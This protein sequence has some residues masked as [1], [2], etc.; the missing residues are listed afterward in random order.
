METKNEPHLTLSDAN[1]KEILMP[2]ERTE[3]RDF[4]IMEI[5]FHAYDF[6]KQATSVYIKD[7][8][9]FA[10]RGMPRKKRR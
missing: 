10:H 2:G 7:N 3:T 1:G 6:P 4:G 8:S 9:A 5:E